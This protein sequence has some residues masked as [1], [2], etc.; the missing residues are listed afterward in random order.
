M[1]LVLFFCSTQ[2]MDYEVIGKVKKEEIS[3]E[4]GKLIV[5]KGFVKRTKTEEVFSV[6]VKHE[7][8]YANRVITRGRFE[9]KIAQVFENFPMSYDQELQLHEVSLLF[10]KLS[11]A[12][13]NIKIDEYAPLEAKRQE[14]IN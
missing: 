1:S 13:A 14:L 7:F 6:T 12:Y 9:G 2:S 3:S 8:S 5:F 10:S 11:G 4:V